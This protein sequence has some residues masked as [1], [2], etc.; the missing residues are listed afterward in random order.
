MEEE[1]QALPVEAGAG[2]E[3]MPPAGGQGHDAAD[4]PLEPVTLEFTYTRAEFLQAAR[5]YLFASR[6]ISVR[7]LVLVG[8]LLVFAVLYLIFGG[9]NTGSL[10]LLIL[11][12]VCCGLMALLYFY[13]PLRSYNGARKYREGYHLA[14]SDEG[15]HFKTA[16]INSEL[17]W[18]TYSEVWEN[19]AFFY[20]TTG[21]QAYTIIPK[22]AFADE[23]Q[24]EAFRRLAGARIG[25]VRQV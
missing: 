4:A 22:R 16:S 5:Q 23:G 14:F 13:M 15:I 2:A 19:A 25:A 17:A 8:A 3:E 7:N 11:A 24:L 1:R 21:P 9:F 6:A 10:V 12:A 18:S 20:L